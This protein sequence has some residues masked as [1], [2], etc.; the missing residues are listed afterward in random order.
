[1]KDT[2]L[3]ACALGVVVCLLLQ[4]GGFWVSARDTKIRLEQTE[5][6]LLLQR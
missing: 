4:F 1:M 6:T 2:F 5:R 3:G